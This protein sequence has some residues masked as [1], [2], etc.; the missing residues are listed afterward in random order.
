MADG[1]LKWLAALGLLS[2][3]DFFTSGG[4]LLGSILST[5]N[6]THLI[7]KNYSFACVIIDLLIASTGRGLMLLTL[8][9]ILLYNRPSPRLAMSL[10]TTMVMLPFFLFALGIAKAIAIKLSCIGDDNALIITILSVSIAL[11]LCEGLL[12][13]AILAR[14]SYCIKPLNRRQS[15]VRTTAVTVDDEPDVDERTPLLVKNK[16]STETTS[17]TQMKGLIGVS[18]SVIDNVANLPQRGP[19]TVV[20]PRPEASPP[21]RKTSTRRR[22]TRRVAPSRMPTSGT[23]GFLRDPKGRP[24]VP[25]ERP[26]ETEAESVGRKRMHIVNEMVTT[27]DRYIRVLDMIVEVF[28]KPLEAAATSGG[29]SRMSSDSIASFDWTKKSIAITKDQVRAIFLEV[30]SIANLNHQFL[31]ELDKR[32]C[33]WTTDATVGDVFLKYVRFFKVYVTFS[34]NFDVAL[35]TIN[36]CRK[37]SSFK[38][39]LEQCLERPECQRLWLDD[40]L[41]GPIQRIPRYVMLLKDLLR[42]TPPDHPDFGLLREATESYSKLAKEINEAKGKA[43]QRLLTIQVQRMVK[44]LPPIQDP[45]RLFKNDFPCSLLEQTYVPESAVPKNTVA[46]GNSVLMEVSDAVIYL[47]TDIVVVATHEQVNGLLGR[48]GEMLK[49]LGRQVEYDRPV[50]QTADGQVI[51]KYK[52]HSLCDLSQ[53]KVSVISQEHATFRL[54]QADNVFFFR[55]PSLNEQQL[56]F[57]QLQDTR[58]K[59]VEMLARLPLHLCEEKQNLHKLLADLKMERRRSPRSKGGRPDS[60]V[61]EGGSS[62]RLRRKAQQ[63]KRG[64]QRGTSMASSDGRQSP[65]SD[66]SAFTTPQVSASDSS[67]PVSMALPA[68]IPIPPLPE[69]TSGAETSEDVAHKTPITSEALA[70]DIL[71]QSAAP[72]ATGT[73]SSSTPLADVAAEPRDAEEPSQTP[74]PLQQA[75]AEVATDQGTEQETEQQTEQQRVEFEEAAA[76]QDEAAPAGNPD[77]AALSTAPADD[78]SLPSEALPVDQ[79]AISTS[80]KRVVS[81]ASSGGDGLRDNYFEVAADVLDDSADGGSNKPSPELTLSQQPMRAVSPLTSFEGMASVHQPTSAPASPVSA[82]EAVH[83][84]PADGSEAVDMAAGSRTASPEVALPEPEVVASVAA[85]EMEV[86]VDPDES[87][88]EIDPDDN[89]VVSNTVEVAP[90]ETEALVTSPSLVDPIEH[91]DAIQQDPAPIASEVISGTL[92]PASQDAE[93]EQSLAEETDAAAQPSSE[94]SCIPDLEAVEHRGQIE[95]EGVEEG[96]LVD[97]SKEGQADAVAADVLEG[98][99]GLF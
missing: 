96:Q 61:S 81:S 76:L 74:E 43:E 21:V 9:S 87:V 38:Q 13:A 22:A 12:A 68:E 86:D 8:S 89:V 28:L 39:F 80:P 69:P 30:A 57:Q 46:M 79:A 65:P 64:S 32:F 3:V 73:E 72:T 92:D 6:D 85:I 19:I 91:M 59:H 24:V 49:Q 33:N 25:D 34:N 45:A 55:S 93:T 7:T 40:H 10:V 70:T 82:T 66:A 67:R 94:E 60:G 42:R 5:D 37:K 95:E 77:L 58:A 29:S 98:L 48:T 11:S 15:I 1:S 36:Q 14:A 20:L 23:S 53:V 63:A 27:E 31:E 78:D 52:F 44:Y 84:P 4:L 88:V 90:E 51:H 50:E 18:E 99:Q 47:F 83:V 41:I 62:R 2:V 26:D 56:L 16:S 97:Q 17:I 75:G 35:S 54:Q 71:T